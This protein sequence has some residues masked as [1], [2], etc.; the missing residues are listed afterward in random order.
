VLA[1]PVY[2]E[3]VITNLIDN[4]MKYAGDSPEINIKLTSTSEGI[5]VSVRDNGPGIPKEYQQLIFEKFFRVTS[6]NRHEV[7]GYGLGLNF[8]RQVMQQHGGS[9][10]QQNITGGGCEFILHFPTT[11]ASP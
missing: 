2:V 10:S 4:G 9:I 5:F 7:K 8:C 1:D 3:G 6:G 11:S